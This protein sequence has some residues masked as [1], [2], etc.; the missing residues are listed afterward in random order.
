MEWGSFKPRN[1]KHCG[2]TRSEDKCMEQILPQSSQKEPTLDIPG[3]PL[4]KNLP[5]NAGETGSIPGPGR[6]HMAQGN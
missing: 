2:I 4:A 3:G 1:T 6:A 5:A